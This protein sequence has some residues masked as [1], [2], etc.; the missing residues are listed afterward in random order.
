VAGADPALAIG[1]AEEN[2]GFNGI[3]AAPIKTVVI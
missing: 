2:E 1:L 3:E